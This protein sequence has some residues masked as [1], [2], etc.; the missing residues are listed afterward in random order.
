VNDPELGPAFVATAA[1]HVAPGGVVI[2]E[3]YPPGWDPARSIG[4]EGELGDARVELLR[5]HVTRDLLEA[6]VR[7]GVDGRTWQQPFRARLFD[8]AALR[9]LLADAGLR[10]D[11]WLNRPGWFLAR[12]SLEAASGST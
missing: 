1:A 11:R 10:F 7:Y 2:A 5:A 3:T 6:E 12:P 4:I 9:A 8:E